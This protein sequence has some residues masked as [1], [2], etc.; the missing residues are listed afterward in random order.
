VARSGSCDVSRQAIDE[1]KDIVFKLHAFATRA[2]SRIIELSRV[3][4]CARNA[5]DTKI[6][7]LGEDAGNAG[8]SIAGSGI[9]VRYCVLF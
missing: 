5:S 1:E 7:K 6:R 2:A 8:F 4:C 3:V 9:H